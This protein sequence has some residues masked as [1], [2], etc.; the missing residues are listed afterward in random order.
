[1][2]IGPINDSKNI[3]VNQISF[4]EI[5]N[6]DARRILVTFLEKGFRA[7]NLSYTPLTGGRSGAGIIKFSV[8]KQAFV[9]RMFS[10]LDD[11]ET[12]KKEAE[13]TKKVGEYGLAP[14]VYYIDTELKGMVIEFLS[15]RTI[16]NKDVQNKEDL[17]EF[18]RCIRTLHSLPI[19]EPIALTPA[20]MRMKWYQ[21][22]LDNK[23]DLPSNFAKIH[24]MIVQ[25][26]KTLSRIQNTF[27]LT[28]QDLIP[29]NIMKN[30]GF[31]LID[32]PN[33]GVGDPF[34]DLA[35]FPNFHNLDE[36]KT[37]FFLEGYF[38]REVS[39][40]EWNLFVCHRPIPLFW[41]AIGGFGFAG[42]PD[43]EFYDKV[44]SEDTLPT[45]QAL[46]DDFARKK[47]GLTYW[48][49]SLVFLREVERQINDSQFKE[50][51]ESLQ[52]ER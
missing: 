16:S 20:E 43:T 15:G 22:V 31:K 50:S 29:L 32:W 18:G 49:I 7:E 47:L 8:G 33:G 48:Q 34:C 27:V 19:K 6:E 2:D 12:H 42:N 37:R 4:S 46:M 39:E 36:S 10:P 1:M 35:T 40:F 21:R 38:N 44:L 30:Q 3:E 28:H 25:T 24:E 17:L 52:R 5:E 11:R 45:I 9:L 51:L 14:K 23:G 41:R 26:E 13:L